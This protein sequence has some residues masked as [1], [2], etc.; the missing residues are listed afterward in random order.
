M[1][2][3]QK[4]GET[5]VGSIAPTLREKHAKSGAPTALFVTCD[6]KKGGA[7]GLPSC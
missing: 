6:V 1:D 5:S 4:T 3:M 2:G 7:P